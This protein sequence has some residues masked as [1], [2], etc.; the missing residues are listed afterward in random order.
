M[1]H[2]SVHSRTKKSIVHYTPADIEQ[3]TL[4]IIDRAIANIDYAS[5]PVT[6]IISRWSIFKILVMA[7]IRGYL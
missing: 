7:L 6:L 1:N 3:K 4:D 5:E 2:Y